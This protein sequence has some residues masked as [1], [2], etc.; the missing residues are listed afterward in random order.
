MNSIENSQKIDNELTNEEILNHVMDKSNN[1]WA[2]KFVHAS[3]HGGQ[4]KD[5]GNSKAQLHFDVG[6]FFDEFD[7]EDR[8]W[9][10]FVEVFG[11]KKI[12]HNNMSVVL[13][14]QE[15]RS[16]LRN[17]EIALHHLRHKLSE[18]L[19]D[20]IVRK[21][22]KVPYHEKKKRIDDK[23]RKAKKK[24]NRAKLEME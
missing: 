4:H 22:T 2:V 18:F 8:K 6:K 19:E 13:E 12:H 17:Q 10:K 7:P 15:E 16:A 21:E 14:D 23:K 5:H 3:G 11:K 20:D 1:F 24:K 9:E